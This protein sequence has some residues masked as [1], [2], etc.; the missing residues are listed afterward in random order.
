[1]ASGVIKSVEDSGDD[2]IHAHVDPTRYKRQIRAF[3]DVIGFRKLGVMFEDSLDGRTYAALDDVENIARER[4]FEIISCLLPTEIPI[5][6]EERSAIACARELAPKID[7]FYLSAYTRVNPNTI[8][9][10]LSLLNAYN[11]PTFSQAGANEVKQGVLLSVA[12]AQYK[13]L[14][15]FHAE[16]LAKI[17][18][19]AKP[20]NLSQVFAPPVKITFNKATARIIDLRDDIYRFLSDVA[21]EVYEEIAVRQ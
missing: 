8:P 9:Q 5:E 18:N 12:Q 1:V 14:G 13:D 16:T 6:D 21:D 19:G 17:L 11:I 10:I 3:H 4:G 15:C 2:H 20:R 7:A